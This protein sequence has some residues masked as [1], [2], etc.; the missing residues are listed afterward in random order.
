ME[1]NISEALI[2]Q[3]QAG[4]PLMREQSL[5]YRVFLALAVMVGGLSNVC[6]KQLLLPAQIGGLDP[7][8]K[9]TS[10]L[11]VAAIGAAVGMI[12]A[13]VTG[14]L[15]DRSIRRRGKRRPW[16]LGGIVVAAAGMLIMA[17]SPTIGLLVLGEILAQIG[18]DGILAVTTA[19]IPEQV[20]AQQQWLVTALVGIAPNV[21][22]VIG[23]LLVTSF[24]NVRLPWQGYVLMTVVSLVCI[25][26]FL[27]IVREDQPR[28]QEALPPFHL[29]SFLKGFA[30]PLLVADF[31]STFLSRFL[32]YMAF[33][34][35]GNYT[36]YYL[37]DR[38]LLPLPV[39]A[40]RLTIF[41]LLS[42]GV[43]FVASVLAG[44][45]VQKRWR[46]RL[47]LVVM[48]GA[49]WDGSRSVSHGFCPL[50]G[51]VVGR[52]SSLR[53]GLWGLPGC[54]CDACPG[55]TAHHKR[56]W[57]RSR[58]DVYRHFLGSYTQPN[59]RGGLPRWFP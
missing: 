35:L 45:L 28:T 33:T 59:S 26:V 57:E 39:A 1:K 23:L 16:I 3:K 47:K 54:R 58:I 42:T 50:V 36:L 55:S 24:T 31:R 44:W 11:I 19:L 43:L 10:L 9:A 49:G 15:S 27:F 22:G 7:A 13:P 51:G 30:R 29:G 25:G 4:V 34:I 6:I 52:S 46:G 20:P 38:L 17:F 56:S 2:E 14:A 37:L 40:G 21:G 32:A 53:T 48:A 8:H 5:L 41:Q 12:A 18:V